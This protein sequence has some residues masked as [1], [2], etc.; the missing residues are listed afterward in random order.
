M[1]KKHDIEWW[2]R[3]LK[4]NDLGDMPH[5]WQKLR[6]VQQAHIIILEELLQQ[7]YLVPSYSRERGIVI[8]AGG[9]TFF[10]CAFACFYTLRKLGCSLPFEFWYLDDYEMDNKMLDICYTFGIEPINAKKFCEKNNI[11]PRI[12]GG[13]ELKPFSVL[14]SKFKEVLYLDADNIPVRDVTFLF[15]ELVYKSLGSIFWPDLKP[16]DRQEWVP[17]ICWHNIGME[18]QNSRDF[19]SGQFIINKEKCYKEL[20]IT[21]W[22][23]EHSDW[24]YKFVFG[25]KS[26][27]HLAWKKCGTPYGMPFRGAGWK[28]IAILQYDLNR[29]LLFQHL[30]SGK[31]RMMHGRNLEGILNSEFVYEAKDIREKMWTGQIYS[32]SEMSNEEYALARSFMGDYYYNRIGLGIRQMRLSEDGE[33]SIGS[34]ACEKRWSIRIIDNIPN[35]VIVGNGHKSS[36]V[37]MIFARPR[38][39]SYKIFDGRWTMYEKSPIILSKRS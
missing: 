17:P 20:F 23:N 30:T 31:D 26:T 6:E 21:T 4:S 16:G 38:D 24:F 3:K 22:M 35:I 7:E 9:T 28:Q 39:D 18:Y 14:H 10:S 12:L 8:C 19:E 33:I 37:G 2:V 1:S 11:H 13:W 36:E 25:D 15:D 5:N 27:F 32:W 34:A 29:K